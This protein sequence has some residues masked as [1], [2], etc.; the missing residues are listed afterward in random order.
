M[1]DVVNSTVLC[2][3]AMLDKVYTPSRNKGKPSLLSCWLDNDGLS[4]LTDGGY[5]LSNMVTTD[6][7]VVLT[8]SAVHCSLPSLI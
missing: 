1:A 8:A 3:I 4:L 6:N 5:S 2:V 7:T